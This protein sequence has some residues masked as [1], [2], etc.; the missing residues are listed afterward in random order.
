M[1]V[2]ALKWIRGKSALK[3]LQI[4]S[5]FPANPE[6]N[7]LLDDPGNEHRGQNVAL[8]EAKHCQVTKSHK[9]RQPQPTKTKV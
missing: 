8:W 4:D 1:S 3:V 2:L 5:V 9:I 6:V 7:H